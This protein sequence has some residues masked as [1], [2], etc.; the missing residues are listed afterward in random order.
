MSQSAC[1]DTVLP[2][3]EH[4]FLDKKTGMKEAAM[5]ANIGTLEGEQVDPA[6]FDP[7]R[8]VTLPMLR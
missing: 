2:Y 5:S 8:Y 3:T 7:R 1:V 6:D 4:C